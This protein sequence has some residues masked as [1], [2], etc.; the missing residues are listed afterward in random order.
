MLLRSC[1]R[2]VIRVAKIRCNS[3]MAS[4]GEPKKQG[5]SKG[6]KGEK[7]SAEL[8]PWP[9][10]IQKR[11]DLFDT[12][13]AAHD[14]DIAAKEP[15][16]I[17]VTLP[18]GKVV[19][20]ES[21]R[22]TP[23]K[24][25]KASGLADN[26]V[27]SKVNGDVWDLD[28]PLEGMPSQVS[29]ND[30]PGINQVV[31]TIQKEKQPFVRLEMKKEDLLKMF[32]YNPFKQR[33]LNEKVTTP[34]TTVYR[35]GPLID[36]CRGPHVR[37]TGKVKAF[38]VVKN[39]A[40]Y[41]EGNSE[42]ESLQRIYGISFPDNK[43]LKEWKHLQEEAA[44]RD[45]RK[46]GKEQ[47]LF[48]FHELSPGSC[49][50]QPKGAHIYNILVELIRSEYKKRGYQEVVSPN[51][52]NK[53]LW[54]TSG[55]W[56]HYD[57]NIFKFDVEKETYALKPMNCP[58]HCLIFDH[59]PR[60]WRELPLRMADFGVLH[61]NELSGA[62]TGLTRVRRFQ[63]DDAHIFC[64]PE[65]IQQEIKGCLDF[66]EAVYTIFGFTYKLELS[67]RPKK[68]LGEVEVWDNAEKQLAASLDAFGHP[69][70]LNPEDGAFYGPK[71]DITIQDAL[72]RSHQC[73]TIQLD[74]QL[75]IRFNLKYVAPF[76]ISPRQAIVV[77]VGPAFNAY[78]ETV[79]QRLHDAGFMVEHDTDDS[80]TMNKKIRNA[81][82]SQFNFILV[83]GEKEQT[84]ET[85]NVRT[86]DNLV[87]GER[88]ITEVIQRFTEL[89]EKR[90][91][92]SEESF[93]DKKQEE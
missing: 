87:H 20:G 70:K 50:F 4:E 92:Q 80:D 76:W 85:V 66:L 17:K 2:R 89:N 21:W 60:S 38:D 24:L 46:I 77:P 8:N 88:S 44:K 55:H 63:Q 31:K 37:H 86:R 84:N 22:T 90:I 43:Q 6:G 41:W 40:T 54:E 58:G 29:S 32:D 79:T 18:D 74:F 82:L 10:Y 26:A 35:C 36:L 65:L 27:I 28:R 52:Y 61:R 91:I 9:E 83:V 15:Q 53:K 51:I 5:K 59:R 67:T 64:P 11:I 19:D 16:A 93:G 3:T 30:F 13:K 33:I 25:L 45:H 78:A 39:S 1:L 49:F 71:I 7:K 12:L 57:D 69:W 42:A 73:A 68:Y 47:G 56:Q 62:L 23:I 75:P 72:R 48:F 34:T 81:Q 14:A